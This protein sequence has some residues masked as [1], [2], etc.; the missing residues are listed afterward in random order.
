MQIFFPK[1]EV[2]SGLGSQATCIMRRRIMLV[3]TPIITVINQKYICKKRDAENMINSQ[4][5]TMTNYAQ[6][7]SGHFVG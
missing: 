1:L 7:Q 6:G 2:S 3:D 4:L 5:H